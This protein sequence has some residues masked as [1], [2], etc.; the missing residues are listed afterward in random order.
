MVLAD[1]PTTRGDEITSPTTAIYL[2]IDYIQNGQK[3]F[4]RDPFQRGVRF[5]QNT[6]MLTGINY[7]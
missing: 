7:V 6:V 3:L 2:S 4:P 5:S 1:L